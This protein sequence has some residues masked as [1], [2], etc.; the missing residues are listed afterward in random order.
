MPGKLL[1][2]IVHKHDTQFNWEKATNFI[3]MKGE[4]IIYD[5]DANHDY[6]RI[7]VGDG[8]T[9]I[10]N[11][12]FIDD[13]VKTSLDDALKNKL[14]KNEMVQSD[15]SQN[16]ETKM[17]YIKNRPFY[18]IEGESAPQLI[19][20]TTTF[21][22]IGGTGLSHTTSYQ[23][24][25][26]DAN[27][28]VTVDDWDNIIFTVVFDGVTYESYGW[29]GRYGL[30]IGNVY[31]AEEGALPFAPE[32]FCIRLMDYSIDNPQL[33]FYTEDN[34]QH[35]IK[36]YGPE[37]NNSVLVKIPEEFLPDGLA[38][39]EY[40]NS[41]LDNIDVSGFVT[42]DSVQGLSDE[43][44]AQARENIS[45]ATMID[46]GLIIQSSTPGSTKYFKLTIDDDGVMTASEIV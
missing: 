31:L 33:I 45:A 17:D 13:A 32:P 35:T 37:I 23:S 39:E 2:R 41:A 1:G 24:G 46:K 44:K 43:Q 21:T 22:P 29:T 6:E 5:I 11:L 10:N 26:F 8:E 4:L 38:T 36:I 18:K 40:V 14:D 7:K 42:Y 12:P 27:G 20:D 28:F 16:D 3:P 9:L 25:A 15:W 19:L 30:Y 34:N